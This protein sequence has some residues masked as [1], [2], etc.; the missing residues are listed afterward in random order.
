MWLPKTTNAWEGIKVIMIR[1]V[2]NGGS[3]MQPGI[4][5]G[6][7]YSTIEN[8]IWLLNR[9]FKMVPILSHNACK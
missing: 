2:Y 3:D 4:D 9:Y 8:S 6:Y 1:E 7:S 5:I